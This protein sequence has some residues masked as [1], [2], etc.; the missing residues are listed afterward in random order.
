MRP[1][2]LA[3]QNMEEYLMGDIHVLNESCPIWQWIP[4]V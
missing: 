3:N 4:H 2:Q 1:E